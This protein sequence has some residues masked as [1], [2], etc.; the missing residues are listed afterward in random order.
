MAT[1]N[2]RIR[3]ALIRRQMD[4]IRFNG[5][6]GGRVQ[7]LLRS[8]DSALRADLD[9]RLASLANPR[10][11]F[12]KTTT[13]KLKAMQVAVADILAPVHK[14]A[15]ALSRSEL[16][17]FASAESPFV[18]G[19][20]TAALPVIADTNLPNTA[21]IR[22]LVLSR[23]F[24][25]KLLRQWFGQLETADRRRVN[26]AVRT[27]LTLGETPSQIK[28]RVFGTSRNPSASARGIT[29]SGAQGIIQTAVTHSAS[30]GRT[31]FYAANKKL[32]PKE[33]YVAT[34]DSATT[35]QCKSLDGKTFDIGKGPIPPVHFN[36]RSLRVPFVDGAQA[37]TR[38]ANRA[39]TKDLAGLSGP[40]RRR[41]VQSLVGP[42][43]ARQSYSTF[44]NNQSVGF[45]NDALGVTKAKL[46]R[47]GKLPLDRFV[48]EQGRELTLKEL[49]QRQP[50]AFR[51]AGLQEATETT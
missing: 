17:S 26:D 43:P 37:G 13:K 5:S 33:L 39:T 19:V 40:E 48:T 35:A 41:K 22:N 21:Q 6:L 34:L 46:F 18:Q 27:G 51:L 16:V 2:E 30:S 32:I 11:N 8:V 29:A 38:P 24:E 1:S 20:V 47:K 10:V 15:R 44:L 31:A 23:P 12:G 3:D 50:E 25:G 42:V 28:V 4:A 49:R 45:Q 7:S 36:C 14:E 9:K